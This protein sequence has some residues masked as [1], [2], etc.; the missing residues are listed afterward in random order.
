MRITHVEWN[1]WGANK[2][3]IVGIK[4]TNSKGQS[5]TFGSFE[6]TAVGHGGCEKASMTLKN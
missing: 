2:G 4:F 3:N 6:S 1:I 5:Y